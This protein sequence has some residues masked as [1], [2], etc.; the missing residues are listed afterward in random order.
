M[1]ITRINPDSLHE[2]AGYAHI[3]LV[4]DARMIHLAGQ[5]PLRLDGTTVLDG[6]EPL[7]IALAQTDQV[8][9]NTMTALAEAGAT[10]EDVIR[11]TIFVVSSDSHVLADVWRRFTESR[12]GPAFSTASTLVG[13]TALGYQ[14][15][16]VE[17]D[18]TAA[19]AL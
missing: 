3:T 9:E 11:T 18:V 15:Q 6:S 7:E 16:L 2:T 17:L 4:T 5:C 12:L 1:P 14:G 13:V 8:I 19:V 10:P